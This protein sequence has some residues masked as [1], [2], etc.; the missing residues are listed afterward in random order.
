[1]ARRFGGKYSPDTDDGTQPVERGAF[2]GA[3]TDPVGLRANLLFVPPAILIFFSLADG[4]IGLSLGLLG[5]A[6]LTL[7]AWILRGGLRAEVEYNARKVAR[8]PVFPRKIA[9]SVLTGLGIGTAALKT[10]VVEAALRGGPDWAAP[11]L[12]GVVAMLLHLAAFGL[13]PLKNKGMAGIDT[14]QQDRVARV[15]K[16]AETHLAAM[17]D[18]VKRTGD[19]KIEARVERFQ[20]TARDMFRTV[21][22]DPRDLTAARKYMTVYLLGARDAAIKFAD[23]YSRT[24][25]PA[26]R[27]DFETLLDDLEQNFAARTRRMLLDDRSDLTVEIDV[28]RERL[29]REGVHMRNVE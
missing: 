29:E 6:L 21:E 1:M 24:P 13:D 10:E 8:R 2:D 14:F 11:V 27:S 26:A 5:A 18:A 7:A 3:K 22:E 20:A 16:E 28:L 12:F 25:D 17:A 23:L 9:A 19:R 4:A 15:V